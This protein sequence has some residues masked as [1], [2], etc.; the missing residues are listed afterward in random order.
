LKTSGEEGSRKTSGKTTVIYPVTHGS[1]A[2]AS[3]VI[4]GPMAIGTAIGEQAC[5][6][7]LIDTA[8]PACYL[9]MRRPLRGDALGNLHLCMSFYTVLR[10]GTTVR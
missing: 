1:M 4:P 8:S 7:F 6:C 3:L 2:N 10:Q 5:F 9:T